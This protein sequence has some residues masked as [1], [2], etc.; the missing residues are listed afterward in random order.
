MRHLS[1]LSTLC[2]VLVLGTIFGYRSR[3]QARQVNSQVRRGHM[4]L[5]WIDKVKKTS[6][7]NP[8]DV[9]TITKKLNAKI[10]FDR[11]RG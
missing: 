4:N 2:A 11:H 7:P 10:V 6:A 5:Q 8:H 3:T 9:E 1:I